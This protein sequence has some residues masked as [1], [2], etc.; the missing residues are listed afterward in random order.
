MLLNQASSAVGGAK[1][2]RHRPDPPALDSI[3]HQ[4]QG[5]RLSVAFIVRQQIVNDGKRAIAGRRLAVQA[6]C[7]RTCSSLAYYQFREFRREIRRSVSHHRAGAPSTDDRTLPGFQGES[8]VES[9]AK[10]APRCFRVRV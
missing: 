4:Q 7:P 8:V 3:A 9:A 1:G 2:Q 6:S 10:L 5:I